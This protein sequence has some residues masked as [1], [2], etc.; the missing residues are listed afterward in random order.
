MET[1]QKIEKVDIFLTSVK[2]PYQITY[3]GQILR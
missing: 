3:S 2:V 1:M